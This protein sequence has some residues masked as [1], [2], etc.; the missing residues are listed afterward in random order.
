MVVNETACAWYSEGLTYSCQH[1]CSMPPEC[2]M[3]AVGAISL[4]IIIFA[5]IWFLTPVIIDVA[6]GLFGNKRG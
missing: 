2:H 1:Y 3:N 5:A 4:G 6:K